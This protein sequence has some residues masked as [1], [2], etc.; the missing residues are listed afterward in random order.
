MASV[1]K[2][3]KL[4]I[5]GM[6]CSGCQTVIEES[7]YQAPGVVSV[8]ASYSNGTADISYNSA[9]ISLTDIAV[10]LQSH[11][12]R[13]QKSVAGFF[14]LPRAAGLL[15]V[16]AALYLLVEQSG[17]LNVLSPGQLA[18]SGMSYG[19]LFIIGL[20][21]SVHC[22]AMCGGINLSQCLAGSCE[23]G[24]GSFN[25]AFLYNFG[26][27]VSYTA[28]GFIVGALGSVITFSNVM[29]GA[30]K[31]AAGAFMVIMGINMLGIFPWLRRF[32]PKLPSGLA[33]KI[34]RKKAQSSSPLIVGILNGLMPCGP[35]QAM[36]L[37]ALST[38]SAVSGAVSM[39]MFSLGTVPLMLGLGALSTFLSKKHSAKMM[40]AGAVLVAVLGLSMF[41]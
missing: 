1:I 10:I 25:A 17:L 18:Q 33:K 31:L 35:L 38:G 11:G 7:L 6:T 32:N 29:Q 28:I 41:S 16:I 30:L 27:V 22:I 8:R 14:G 34:G 36:Q 37:Y 23:A 26:R 9:V 3:E 19:M 5:S 12:Y 4:Y 24:S 21:T 20:M 15:A 39:L 2:S 13:L 40:T